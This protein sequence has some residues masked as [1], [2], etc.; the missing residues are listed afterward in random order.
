MKNWRVELIIFSKIIIVIR[1]IF[2]IM[3]V[4]II[5]RFALTKT[6]FKNFDPILKYHLY[7][8]LI[9]FII[10][11]PAWQYLK[12]NSVKIKPMQYLVLE[13]YIVLSIIILI[14]MFYLDSLKLFV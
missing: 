7:T 9:C 10:S 3:F 14:E 12:T 6:L 11:I 1:E 5:P 8:F 4:Y 2:A 13:L